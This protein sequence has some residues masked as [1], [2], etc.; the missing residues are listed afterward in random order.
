MAHLKDLKIRIRSV[1]STQKITKAMKMVAAS[2][3]KK[4][5]DAVDIIRPYSQQLLDICKITAQN[6]T[7]ARNIPLLYPSREIK[8]HLCIVLSSDRGLCGGLNS[9]LVRMVKKEIAQIKQAGQNVKILCIGKKAYTQLNILKDVSV[10]L[11]KEKIYSKKQIIDPVYPLLQ[12]LMQ[13]YASGEFDSCSVF[14]NKFESA[15][16]YQNTS[17]QLIPIFNGVVEPDVEASLFDFEPEPEKMI[18][19]L[20]EQTLI[21]NLFASI[22]E[23]L[24]SEHG[25]RMTAMENATNNATEMIKDLTILY[26]RK[27]QA[28]ITKELIEIISG[29]EAI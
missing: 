7:N 10:V 3:L 2:K 6:T 17:V 4:A 20:L 11:Y 5:K 19:L 24:A 14:Y 15:V 21:T 28:A 23:N 27:R 8:T 12:Q 9:S 25:A 18:H 29:A 16:K 1:K 22:L 13:Q 26:N